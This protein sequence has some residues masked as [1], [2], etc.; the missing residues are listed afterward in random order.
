MNND[1]L[2]PPKKGEVRNPKGKPK[3]TRNR[4]T[5]VREWLDTVCE[6]TNPITD[7]IEK[8][9]LADQITIALIGK[10]RN[11]DVQAYKELMDSGFGKI[12]DTVEHDVNI[13]KTVIKWGNSEIEI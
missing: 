12:K 7:K 4:A 3:G 11:G 1:N 2:K 9:T 5:I 10:A 8:K 6:F 13:K